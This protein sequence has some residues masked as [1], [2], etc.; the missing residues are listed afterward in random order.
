MKHS[1]ACGCAPHR[2]PPVPMRPAPC[3]GVLL[4]RI[5]SS[6]KRVIP[7]LCT[8]LEAFGLPDCAPPLRLVRIV[9]AEGIPSWTVTGD[10]D[11]CGRVPVCVS[12][13]VR[14]I[15]CDSCGR[16]HSA[17]AVIDVQTWIPCAMTESWGCRL[18]IVPAIQLLCRECLSCDAHFE[19]QLHITLDFYLLR[20]EAVYP[21]R[22]APACP[23]LPLYPPPICH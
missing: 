3:T 17:T 11:P 18:H 21:G 12:I 1:S 13:P 20:P 9:P 6:E 16:T 4:D 14:M 7:R 5:I 15:L 19:V 22:P 23:D 10:P 2:P 8:V